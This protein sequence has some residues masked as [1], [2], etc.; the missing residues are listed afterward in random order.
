MAQPDGWIG[1]NAAGKIWMKIREEQ[2]WKKTLKTTCGLLGTT[3]N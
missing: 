3:P 2:A 1:E